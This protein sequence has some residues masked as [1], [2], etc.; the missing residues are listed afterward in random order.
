M[1]Y[2]AEWLPSTITYPQSTAAL[3][4]AHTP[5]HGISSVQ[6]SRT[7]LN[8]AFGANPLGYDI[9]D[10]LRSR[11]THDGK[12]LTQYGYTSFVDQV[13]SLGGGEG[14]GTSIFGAGMVLGGS[15]NED[16]SGPD[17]GSVDPD[18]DGLDEAFA[19]PGVPMPSCRSAQFVGNGGT[20]SV[21]T[22][23]NGT[24]AWGIKMHDHSANFGWWVWSAYVGR[25]RVDGRAQNYN[26][27]GSVDPG[28]AKSFQVLRIEATLMLRGPKVAENVP[29]ACIIP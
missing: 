21:Q 23:L 7:A 17:D 24:V 26:P 10:R 29:N 20:I 6:Y 12:R 4:L 19:V 11:A 2:D 15:W 1:Q 22:H 28:D 16:G 13:I 5:R 14:R 27:H 3:T 18:L 25:R 9:L 8:T